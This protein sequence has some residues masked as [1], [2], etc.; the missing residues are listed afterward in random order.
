MARID[1][2]YLEGVKYRLDIRGHEVVVDQ[3]IEAGG[4]DAG[5]TPTELYVGGL[6]SCVAFYAG[7]FLER[8]GIEREGLS[9]ACEWEMANDRP[10]RVGRVD[11]SI[12]LPADFPAEQ[13]DRLMAVVEH[14]TVHN[15]MVQMPEVR[16]EARTAVGAN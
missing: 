14:C 15:S 1:V 2:S 13:H 10:N 12:D 8:H 3:P 7:R 6:A 11:I 9:V 5:P 4:G 16:I